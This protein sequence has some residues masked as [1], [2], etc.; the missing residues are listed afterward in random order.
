MAFTLWTVSFFGMSSSS[1]NPAVL[2][3]NSGSSSLKFSLIDATSEEVLVQG[4]AEALGT[5]DAVLHV[6]RPGQGKESL[7]IPNA[8]HSAAMTAVRPE[9]IRPLRPRQTLENRHLWT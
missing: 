3:I 2:V 7:P 6:S 9:S 8:D 1:N 4:L 5:A